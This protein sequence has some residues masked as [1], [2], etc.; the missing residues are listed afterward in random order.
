MIGTNYVEREN[1]DGQ[2]SKDEAYSDEET[3]PRRDEALLRA[4]KHTAEAS[5]GDEDR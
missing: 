1:D 3:T 5:F 2:S 4:L